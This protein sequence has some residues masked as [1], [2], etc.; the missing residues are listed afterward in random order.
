M[1]MTQGPTQSCMLIFDRFKKA[2]D[3]Q[4]E[5][6]KHKRNERGKKKIRTTFFF[7][8]FLPAVDWKNSSKSFPCSA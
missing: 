7:K 6:A 8:S 5:I 3:D 2:S 1:I 4:L